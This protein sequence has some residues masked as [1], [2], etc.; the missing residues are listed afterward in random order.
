[1]GLIGVRSQECVGTGHGIFGRA[2][3]F[4]CQAICGVETLDLTYAACFSRA[5][6]SYGA[7]QIYEVALIFFLLLAATIPLRRRFAPS[8]ASFQR[9]IARSYDERAARARSCCTRQRP[10]SLP[11]LPPA[12]TGR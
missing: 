3:N 4:L 9:C 6:F 7:A 10:S 1:M 8:A 11:Q 2:G 5:F 12:W